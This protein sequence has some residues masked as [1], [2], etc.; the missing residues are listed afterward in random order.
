MINENKFNDSSLFSQNL[1]K[2]RKEKGLTQGD[3]ARLSGIS[4]RMIGYYETNPAK[5]SINKAKLLA[6]AL[7][8]SIEDLIGNIKIV[9]KKDCFSDLDSR[10]IKRL[11][12]ILELTQNERHLVYVFVDSLLM[13]RNQKNNKSINNEHNHRKH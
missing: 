2:I 12:K 5:P 7:G 4:R 8:V 13:K 9:Q 1:I 3:L 10:T 6:K 11:K